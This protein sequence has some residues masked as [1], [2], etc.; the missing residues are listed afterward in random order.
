VTA[1]RLS[2]DAGASAWGGPSKDGEPVEAVGDRMD[3]GAVDERV[4]D[5]AT[6]GPPKAKQEE[7]RKGKTRRGAE[8]RARQPNHPRHAPGNDEIWTENGG[9]GEHRRGA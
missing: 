5:D 4:A 6:T 7:T 9:P 1:T 8:L 3:E 2:G